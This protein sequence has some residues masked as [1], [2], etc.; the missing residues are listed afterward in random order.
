M[1]SITQGFVLAGNIKN[2]VVVDVDVKK[3]LKQK[4]TEWKS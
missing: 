2:L 1:T 3:E 4:N